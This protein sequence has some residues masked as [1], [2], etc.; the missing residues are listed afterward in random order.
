ML[1]CSFLSF[2]HREILSQEH[3]TD[4]TKAAKIGTFFPLFPPHTSLKRSNMRQVKA[5]QGT[6]PIVSFT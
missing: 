5:V 1:Q 2:F 3:C 6:E 4:D